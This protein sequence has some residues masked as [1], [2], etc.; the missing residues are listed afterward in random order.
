MYMYILQIDELN[1]QLQK[2]ARSAQVGKNIIIIFLINCIQN[3]LV[4]G[5]YMVKSLS[6]S[7]L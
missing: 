2:Q 3:V 7:H 1:L 6:C 5:C 4:S